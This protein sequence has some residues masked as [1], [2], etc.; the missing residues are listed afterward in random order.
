[1][2]GISSSCRERGWTVKAWAA[3]KRPGA[4]RRSV[5]ALGIF[6]ATTTLVVVGT[7]NAAGAAT[8]FTA[9]KWSSQAIVPSSETSASPALAEYN[10]EL[11]VAYKA[12]SSNNIYYAA[13]T[14]S[15]WSSPKLVSGSWGE[16]DTKAAPA[17]VTYGSKL[18]AFWTGA[19]GDRIWYSTYDGTSWSTQSTIGGSWGHA[20]TSTNEGP[21]LAPTNPGGGETG[22]LYAAW[23]GWHTGRIWYSQFNGSSWTGQWSTP[24][25]T[26][27]APAVVYDALV[28]DLLFSY[29]ANSGELAEG[30]C[31]FPNSCAGGLMNE[32]TTNAADALAQTQAVNH[33]VAWTD[34]TTN[35]IWYAAEIGNGYLDPQFAV[36][37]AR[38][39]AAP[40][41]G[42]SGNTLYVAW[43]GTTA[44]KVFYSVAQTP[45]TILQY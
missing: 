23:T 19:T 32:G 35:Q 45:S 9:L 30:A 18:F 27:D 37:S 15:V 42:V 5:L 1:M 20:L 40:T 21:A 13:S 3:R 26:P 4:I 41:F 43:K 10:G 28:P 33:Y 31:T 36:P 38:T 24:F 16:A 7:A 39:N 22:D 11:Y 17:L 12:K 25:S 14:G 44:G 2:T 34:P 6:G 29:T 8:G